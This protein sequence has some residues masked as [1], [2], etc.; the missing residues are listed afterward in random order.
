MANDEHVALLKKGVK[1]WNAW[2]YENPNILSDL[3][4]AKLSE[5]EP[6]ARYTAPRSVH[7]PRASFLG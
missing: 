3:G 2:R 7:P 5:R 1:A 4:G 6:A